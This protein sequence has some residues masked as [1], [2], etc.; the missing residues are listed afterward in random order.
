[1]R[2]VR[3]AGGHAVIRSGRR[4]PVLLEEVPARE[5]AP[6]LKSYLAQAPGARAHIPVDPR[7]AV[8][9]FEPIAAD[10]PVFAIHYLG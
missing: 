7:Q 9:D 4:K 10:Y 3:A 5:C 6:I 2:N 8:T 1:V